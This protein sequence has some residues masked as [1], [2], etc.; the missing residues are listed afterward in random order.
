M[1]NKTLNKAI[2]NRNDE[3]YTQ[4]NDISNE[5]QH[6]REH[7]FGKTVLCNCDDPAVSNFFKYFS[8]QFEFLGLKKIITTC[9]KNNQIL[10]FTS[11]KVEKAIYL[12]YYGDKNN[13]RVP[14]AEEI[15][16][17][18][19]NG[20]GDFRSPECI[21]F[22]EESDIVCTNPPFSL[23]R[24]Y[25][26]QLIQYKKKFLIIGSNNA[27]T[28]KEIFPLIKNNKL[29]LG[30]NAVTKFAI[31]GGGFKGFGNVTWFTNLPHKKRNEEIILCKKYHGNEKDY[32][33]YD[34]Y[35]AINID[36]VVDIP[37]DY[38]GIMGVP[39][40]FLD[41]YNPNQFEI[42]K[43]RKG[44]DNRDLSINGNCPYFRILI[45]RK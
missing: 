27:I 13:N 37:M 15:Q 6:Y 45:R 21:K 8:L 29:W 2:K 41:K 17:K 20:D 38:D 25:V 9:Y 30:C 24:E 44:D 7:F 39:I 18:P 28:Y 32:P 4:L 10:E 19:L 3:F 1:A 22:L 42:V 11:K 14:D 36:K 23:F 43:F 40:S 26:A 12:E 35:N 33:K 16:V 31:P 5:L 34:N